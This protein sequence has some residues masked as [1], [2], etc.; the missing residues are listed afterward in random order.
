[1]IF[2]A[3][4][5]DESISQNLNNHDNNHSNGSSSIKYLKFINFF[6]NDRL[7]YFEQFTTTLEI[8]H[9]NFNNVKDEIDKFFGQYQGNYGNGDGRSSIRYLKSINFTINNRSDYSEQLITTIKM[10]QVNINNTE[11]NN[12][13]NTL[14]K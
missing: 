13:I 2:L 3:D 6:V 14:F 10:T 9:V 4:E 7:G 5:I 1:M 12:T 8:I 11:V